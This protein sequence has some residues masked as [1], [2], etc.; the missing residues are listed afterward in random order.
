MGTQA[1]GTEA[2]GTEPTGTQQHRTA[3]PG[4]G[5]S[6][7]RVVRGA[8][9]AGVALLATACGSSSKA[10]SSTAPTTAPAAAAATGTTAPA[11][12]AAPAGAA[13]TVTATLTDFH[14]ALSPATLAPGTY[15]VTVKDAGA[16]RHSL[17]FS[18]PGGRQALGRDIEPG[19]SA[20]MTVVLQAGTYDVFCPVPGHKDLGM[21]LHLQVGAAAGS[22]PATTA[23]P[24]ATSGSGG[25]G[26]GY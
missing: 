3:A 21:D 16:T 23:T 20:T 11:G 26:G 24:A 6:R 5:R 9:V 19:Q 14:I 8:L 1:M 25:Y 18:G 12:S 22:T 17:V 4:A 15:T 13:A 2:R 10:S 7:S